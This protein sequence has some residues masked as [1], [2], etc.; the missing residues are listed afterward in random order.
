MYLPYLEHHCWPEEDRLEIAFKLGVVG[1]S[2]D[3]QRE[4]LGCASH[5]GD[6]GFGISDR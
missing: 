3:L 4:V 6:R 5:V 1:N 2:E